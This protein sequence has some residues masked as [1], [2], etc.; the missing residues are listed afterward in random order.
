M[1]HASTPRSRPATASLLGCPSRQ[2]TTSTTC[3]WTTL[4]PGSVPVRLNALRFVVLIAARRVRNWNVEGRH[5]S[6]AADGSHEPARA[7]TPEYEPTMKALEERREGGAANFSDAAAGAGRTRT[8]TVPKTERAT[9]TSTSRTRAR[10]RRSN[11]RGNRKECAA[12]GSCV[13]EIVYKAAFINTQLEKMLTRTWSFEQRA[14]GAPCASPSRPL[15]WLRSRIRCE[16]GAVSARRQPEAARQQRN[17]YAE[18]ERGANSG[19]TGLGRRRPG[20]RSGAA[21]H[22]RPPMTAAQRNTLRE[23]AIVSLPQ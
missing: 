12:N 5:P 9:T 11:R 15:S 22:A 13:S 18:R 10:T 8:P 2:H 3:R 23:N 4:Q 17:R 21:S 16:N 6:L 20:R 14:S 7:G 19:L 1:R